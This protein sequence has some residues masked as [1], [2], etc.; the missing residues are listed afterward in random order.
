[1][2]LN[3]CKNLSSSV[4]TVR[5]EFWKATEK[6]KERERE[7]V[8]RRERR[9]EEKRREEK[10][11]KIREIREKRTEEK[12]RGGIC[13]GFLITTFVFALQFLLLQPVF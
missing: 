2:R 4:S 5:E 8:T 3:V 1:M 11:R 9:R 10:R 13:D 7:R 6:G 12:R